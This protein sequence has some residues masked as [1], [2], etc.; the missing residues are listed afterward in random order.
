MLAFLKV[1]VRVVDHS[2]RRVVFNQ[3]MQHLDKLEN[4]YLPMI[5]V[6]EHDLNFGVLS[7]LDRSVRKLEISNIGSVP[8]EV[9]FIPKHNEVFYCKDWLTIRPAKIALKPGQK[10]DMELEMTVD[11][12][13]VRRLQNGK[14]D[15][16][17]ILILHVENGKDFF[18]SVKA[19]FGRTC[20]GMPIEKL[21]ANYWD[22]PVKATDLASPTPT[23]SI[24]S[25]PNPTKFQTL[26]LNQYRNRSV[27]FE[28]LWLLWDFYR[29]CLERTEQGGGQISIDVDL[30]QLSAPDEERVKIRDV[31]DTRRVDAE[32]GS[33]E[34]EI[35]QTL[36]AD[37]CS[38]L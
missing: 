10:T 4:D 34:G 13:V 37:T 28:L 25:L 23:S 38:L 8:A 32:E 2:R 26:I 33:A 30:F 18:I 15:L 35:M 36:E 12:E 24:P 22:R 9:T 5:S 7:F 29:R 31:L 20:F 19:E 16:D 21:I 3:I 14:D 1:A 6:S 27:P 17:D 11:K